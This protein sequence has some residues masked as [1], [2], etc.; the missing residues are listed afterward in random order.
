MW[1]LITI[2]SYFFF[3]LTAIADKF[4]L[5]ESLKPKV[6]AFYVGFLGA[7]AVFLIPFVSFSFPGIGQLLLALLG[8]AM[9]ILALFCLYI[10]INRFEVSRISPAVGG[11]VPVVTLILGILFLGSQYPSALGCISFIALILGSFL[12]SYKKEVS[13]E[14]LKIAS[15]AALFF[16]LYFLISKIVYLEQPFWQGFIWMR[17]GGLLVALT[18]LLSREVKDEI[19]NKKPILEKKTGSIF[20]FAQTLG[21]FGFVLQNLAISLVP[22]GYLCVIN[23]LEGTKFVFVLIFAT[24]LS[25]RFPHILKEELSKK[26]ILQ[27]IIAILIIIIGLFVLS[28][29]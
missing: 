19:F 4:I 5:K 3:A 7:L 17:I 16:S 28:L 20:I 14:S 22:S 29:V 8:G 26:T 9:Y 12:I 23:A 15:A 25:I 21:A 18:F 2:L 13:F 10:G 11:L 27:K 1:V 6:Y 24:F